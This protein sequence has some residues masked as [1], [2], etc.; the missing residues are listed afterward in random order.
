M[1]HSVTKHVKL[2]KGLCKGSMKVIFDGW[3]VHR[4]P[5]LR[6]KLFT[7]RLTGKDFALRFREIVGAMPMEYLT[8]RHMLLAASI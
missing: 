1:R 4:R 8:R 2:T 3:R 5:G 6:S 7:S